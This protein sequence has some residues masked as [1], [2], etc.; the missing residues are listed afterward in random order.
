VGEISYILNV[1][2]VLQAVVVAEAVA[3]ATNA[4]AL[5]TL[6]VTAMRKNVVI[7]A[8]KLDIL[9]GIAPTREPVVAAVEAM[10]VGHSR[11]VIEAVETATTVAKLDI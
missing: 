11:E 2:F 4:T 10:A 8:T 3:N 6:H 9:Q 5:D 7:D 1:L